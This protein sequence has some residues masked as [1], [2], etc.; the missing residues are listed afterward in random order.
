VGLVRALDDGEM[1]K[2]YLR[3]QW[4]KYVSDL[5][6]ELCKKGSR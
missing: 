2:L 3:K 5:K 6:E 4:R 1:V